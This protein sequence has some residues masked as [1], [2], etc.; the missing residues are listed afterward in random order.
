MRTSRGERGQ[1][2]VIAAAFMA[3]FFLPLAVLV[4]DGGLVESAYAQLGE[5]LQASTEDGASM[6]DV[7]VFR[8]SDGQRAVLDVAAA[9]VTCERSIRTS[10]L[11][12]IV[13]TTVT[14]G[15]DTVTASATIRV[16]LLIAGAITLTETRSAGFHYGT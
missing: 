1:V 14:V 10:G 15:D 6:I 7:D 9:K 5:T 4:V 11:P 13:S 16:R 3:F 2:L 12:G 8:Q